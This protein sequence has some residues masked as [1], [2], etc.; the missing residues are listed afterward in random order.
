MRKADPF[1]LA[2]LFAAPEPHPVQ[3]KESGLH[4]S[5]APTA[6]R[7]LSNYA[8]LEFQAENCR[9]I[10]AADRKRI[11]QLGSK[12]LLHI[13]D[14]YGTNNS[15]RKA[16]PFFLALLFAAP[17]PHPVGEEQFILRVSHIAVRRYLS[18]YAVLEFQA[19]NCPDCSF[20]ACFQILFF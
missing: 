19:E 10:G 3:K 18:N 20:P 14:K 11:R 12:H 6:L 1:F 17:E 9:Y 2:L 13:L 4:S 7:Y 8:V 16:D 5:Q 15:I